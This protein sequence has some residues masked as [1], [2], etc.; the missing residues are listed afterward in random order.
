MKC[1]RE[2]P[3]LYV[4]PF[5]SHDFVSLK[6]ESSQ[7]IIGIEHFILKKTVT[8]RIAVTYLNQAKRGLRI[9]VIM[10]QPPPFGHMGLA[11][12]LPYDTRF[13]GGLA[14]PTSQYRGGPLLCIGGGR[15]PPFLA[16]WA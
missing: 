2:M 11:G 14:T 1:I 8:Y 16:K 10:V 15:K 13:G 9:D 3:K 5:Q 6:I 4:L 12:P 7:S